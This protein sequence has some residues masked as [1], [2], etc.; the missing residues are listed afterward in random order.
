MATDQTQPMRVS[1]T[2]DVEIERDD[3]GSVPSALTKRDFQ[4][5]LL[6]DLMDLKAGINDGWSFMEEFEQW[7][8]TR[9][10][11]AAR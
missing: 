4:A 7:A 1:F 11:V 3:D 6:A 9:W 2:V 5:V 10:Q 8:I